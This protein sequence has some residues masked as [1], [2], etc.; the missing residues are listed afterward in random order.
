MDNNYVIAQPPQ[1]SVAVEG[2]DARFP[3]RR[4]YCVGRNYTDHIVEMGGNPDRELPFF[5]QKPADSIVADGATVPY[6]SATEDFQ[7]EAELV[8]AVGL[9][10]AD[11]APA[12]AAAHIYGVAVGIDLTRR[13]L[14]LAARNTGRPW[15]AGKSF[16][17]SAPCSAIRPLR[18]APLPTA[19]AIS[20]HVN[21]EPKQRGDV[22]QMIWSAA[23][24][25]HK[26]SQHY[27]IE[28]GDLIYTGTPAGVGA[29]RRGDRVAMA[30]DGV[31]ALSIVVA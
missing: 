11:I 22:S 8:L 25:V 20:L 19:G 14:Q 27:R 7:Y 21:G 16:D 24:I 6:P 5:F 26:L 10:G 15:E 17:Q 13:D 29:M 30:I 3:V 1:A 2:L 12:D 18:G 9:G 4:I 31:G 23:E 28:P